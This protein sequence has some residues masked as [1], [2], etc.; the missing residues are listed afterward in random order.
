[1]L[2]SNFD[3]Y[4]LMQANNSDKWK[5]FLEFYL[6]PWAVNGSA[7]QELLSSAL[8]KA[9]P[10]GP[11]QNL[12]AVD[13]E[14]YNKFIKCLV[15]SILLE[16]L[17]NEAVKLFMEKKE[18]E[19]LQARLRELAARIYAARSFE[20]FDAFERERQKHE[21]EM[22]KM[23]YKELDRIH[24]QAMMQ[25]E[26]LEQETIR[27][28]QEI[29]DHLS[30]RER[31]LASMDQGAVQIA[32]ELINDPTS[33]FANPIQQPTPE[34]MIAH[35]IKVTN[36]V[37]EYTQNDEVQNLQS[38]LRTLDKEKSDLTSKLQGEYRQKHPSKPGEAPLQQFEL[39]RYVQRNTRIQ[40]IE[41][42]SKEINTTLQTKI[43]NI[44]TKLGIT[45]LSK[46]D[47]S[48]KPD[49]E[50]MK[51]AIEKVHQHSSVKSFFTKL[52]D[53][54]SKIAVKRERIEKIDKEAEVVLTNASKEFAKGH[55]LLSEA[56]KSTQEHGRDLTTISKVS[57]MEN[58]RAAR[59]A[60]IKAR[61]NK[62]QHHSKGLGH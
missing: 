25:L 61:M 40:A 9:R 3:I 46:V 50:K 27:L 30:E 34:Q 58:E 8:I 16:N 47:D 2:K 24:L 53:I 15:H 55:A 33:P 21:T 42:R 6:E 22:L 49:P 43:F 48:T 17:T 41:S 62:Q 51:K 13:L 38:E 54:A 29:A 23:I 31:I 36:F 45:T 60:K 35:Q 10:K 7:P 26:Q 44:G 14:K 52:Y 57:A 5:N 37:K 39:N 32:N 56:V 28:T 1:M 59:A 20:D 18:M 11:P 19:K 4:D 12:Q